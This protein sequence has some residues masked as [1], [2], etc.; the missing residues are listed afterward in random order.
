[1][2]GL[3]RSLPHPAVPPAIIVN[4]PTT[5]AFYTND[6]Q[7]LAV[8]FR[9]K[10]RNETHVAWYRDG[11]SLQYSIIRQINTTTSLTEMTFDPI[12]RMHRGE[13]LVVVENS[14]GIIPT[15]QRRVEAR[16]AVE[17]T[18]LPAR[19]TG[20]TISSS[21]LSWIIALENEDEEPDNQTIT[22]RYRNGSLSRQ[23]VVAGDV[24]EQPL[25][26][27]P[28]EWYSV[29]VLAQNQDGSA[30]SQKHSFQT[31]P[32]GTYAWIGGC[33]V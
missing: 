25:P 8:Y 23:S 4:P 18:I 21:T 31:S 20:L 24:R 27:I 33:V 17:V 2:W 11:Q 9:S 13:Y 6:Q 12:R 10:N 1:M 16:F 7:T 26:L 22:V 29:Q 32:G 15:D 5:S 19:P 3:L 28:G 14:H 30:T